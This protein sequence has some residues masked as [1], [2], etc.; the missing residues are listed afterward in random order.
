MVTIRQRSTPDANYTNKSSQLVS[1]DYDDAS[2]S[3]VNVGPINV[4]YRFRVLHIGRCWEQSKRVL[5]H[6][7]A[8][9]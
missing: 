2:L 9:T 6:L 4:N 3:V 7:V 1:T 8:Y 5:A